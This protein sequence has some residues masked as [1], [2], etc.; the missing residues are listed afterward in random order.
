[1]PIEVIPMS[2]KVVCGELRGLG[3]EDAVVRMESGRE[4]VTDN[5][6]WIV[7]ATFGKIKN[8]KKL[9]QEINEIAG[10]VDNGIFTKNVHSAIVGTGNGVKEI[11]R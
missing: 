10:V 9:E 5:S 8:P 1:M 7:H 11:R 3:A 4:F 6:N 2:A